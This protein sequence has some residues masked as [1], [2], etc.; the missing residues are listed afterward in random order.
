MAWL[1]AGSFVMRWNASLTSVVAPSTPVAS[2]P[3]Y[4]PPHRA[5]A[6]PP[7][8]SMFVAKCPSQRY[9]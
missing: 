3:A 1:T 6:R 8:A 5:R 4:S 7:T 2:T 9:V